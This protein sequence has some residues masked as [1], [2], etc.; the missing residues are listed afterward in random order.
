MQGGGALLAGHGRRSPVPST[1]QSEAI[2]PLDG[3]TP[4]V[5]SS[6][7][8]SALNTP[9]D[10]GIGGLV[11]M[12]SHPGSALP[13]PGMTQVAPHLVSGCPDAPPPVV[14]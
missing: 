4:A 2:S 5:V 13:S 14:A 10:G 1:A 8:A 11:D 7:G 9:Y 6:N 12:G 3:S